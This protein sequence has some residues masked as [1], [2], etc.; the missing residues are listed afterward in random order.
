MATRPMLPHPVE[1]G[2]IRAF[3]ASARRDRMISLLANPA[4]RH[5]ALNALSHFADWDG[6]WAQP[7]DPRTDVLRL[8][9]AA[10]APDACHVISED[11][12]IDGRDMPLAGAVEA[13]EWYSF[14]SILCCVPGRLAFFFGEVGTPRLVLLLRRPPL[15]HNSGPS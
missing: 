6:C 12:A 4:R 13:A 7:V 10:G 1:E 2:T 8:L 3:V 15:T 14:A 9:R 5:K 11:S